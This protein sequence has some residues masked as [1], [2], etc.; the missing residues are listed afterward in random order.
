[1]QMLWVDPRVAR[2]VLKRLAH[3]QARSTDPLADAAP[4]KILHEMRL[5]EM[6][7][8]EERPHSPYYGA[9]DSTMLFLIVLDEPNSNLDSEGEEALT[10]AII[11]IR[12][13]MGIVIVVAHRPSAI[14]GVDHLLMMNQGRMQA[15]GPKE[16]VLSKVLQRPLAM[17]RPLKVVPE[18]GNASA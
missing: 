7:A 17:P 6:T 16:E 2:G 12:E 4:G 18:S 9:A 11:G 1:M 5:G 10:K 14:A 13:R 8:F 3:F 15:F